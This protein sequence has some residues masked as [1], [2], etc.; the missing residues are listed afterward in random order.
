MSRD[1]DELPRAAQGR[2]STAVAAGVAVGLGALALDPVFAARSWIPPVV[3]VVAAVSLGGIALRAGLARL[4]ESRGPGAAV[5]A[6]GRAL[7]PA[8]QLLLVLVVL[9]RIF[10]PEQSWAGLVPTPASVGDLLALLGDG[11]AEIREQATPALPLSGLVALTTLF[12]A[13]V[14][15]AVDLLAVPAR[16]PALGGLGL[17]VLYCVPVSTVTGGVAFISFAAPAAGFAVLLWA[18]QRGRLGTSA[19]GGS[20]APLGTGTLPALRTGALALVAGLVLPLFVPTLA[21]GSLASG[22]GGSGTGDG[23]GSA[24]DPVAEMQG[25]LNLPEPIDLLSLDT[26]VDDPGY[27]RAVALDE[28]DEDGWHL[29]NLNGQQSIAQ[30]RPLAPL[31]GRTPSREVRERIT[32]LDHDDQFLPVPYSPQQVEVRDAADDDWRF[33]RAGSTVF[34]RDV[35]TEDLEYEVVAEQPEPSVEDLEAAPALDP[36]DDM[37]RYTE[38][39]ELAPSVRDLAAQLSTGARTPYDRVRAVLDHFTDPANDFVYSLSTTPGTTGDDLA[40]F[41]RLKRGYCEQYAGAMAVLVR[42]TGVPARVVLGYTPGQEQAD[43]ARVV[44][45]DD[46]HAWVEAWFAGIGW[47]P[48]D[49]TPI[50]ANRAVELPWAPRVD[51]TVDETVV[52][53]PVPG[54]ELPL[55]SG[56][57]AELDRDDEFTPLDTDALADDPSPLPWLAGTGAAALVLALAA[58]PALQRRRTRR[59]RLDDGT[60]GELWAELLATTT[61][62]GITVTGTSTAR[63]LAR[64]LAEQLSGAEPAAVTAVRTLALAQERAVYGPPGTAGADPA[65]ATALRTVRR[66]LLRQATRG[67]RLRANVWPAST[68]ADAGR[69]VTARTPRPLRAA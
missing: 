9:T 66:G 25:Q 54:A 50:A 32:V 48:F 58:L 38:L 13:L 69:W 10:T 30:E 55:P 27:L 6:L 52:E 65:A 61:D 8:G 2:A 28:Y 31:P 46:A 36:D 18:D 4:A 44:T 22:I 53:P 34:G 20:G 7:V 39:P 56:P 29:T 60:P 62:L 12:V 1:A 47:I 45:S 64:Q 57:T 59:R 5:P 15:L 24:L 68:L 43:G 3:V 11:L 49:P 37:L 51:A 17:L 35:T 63:Q 42:A 21:E 14:A 41:L 19:D 16:Q 67:Q 26:S 40:D 33:D 23:V